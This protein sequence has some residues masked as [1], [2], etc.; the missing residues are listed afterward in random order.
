MSSIRQF[1][2]SRLTALAANNKATWGKN[3]LQAAYNKLLAAG[4]PLVRTKV[5]SFDIELPFSETLPHIHTSELSRLKIFLEFIHQQLQKHLGEGS[6][7]LT[8]SETGVL[9][10][11]LP[12]GA[13]ILATEGTQ[14]YFDILSKQFSA[15]TNVQFE[16]VRIT[17]QE[18]DDVLDVL[19][20]KVVSMPLN[21]VLQASPRW[22]HSKWLIVNNSMLLFQILE[23]G[24]PWFNQEKPLLQIRLVP[25]QFYYSETEIKLLFQL[26]RDAGYWFLTGF[27]LAGNKIHTCVVTDHTGI[28]NLLR[29]AKTTPENMIWLILL[30]GK[31]KELQQEITQWPR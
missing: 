25:G 28:Q 12:E 18:I 11:F 19:P 27:T 3:L 4:N 29:Y 30:P 22:T 24:L 9:L 14:L 7:V 26:A 10:P 8:G 5:G 13:P 17:N 31:D 23:S 15:L 6:I 2:Y 1:L 16:P 21:W 20:G